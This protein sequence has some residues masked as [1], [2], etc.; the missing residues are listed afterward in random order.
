MAGVVL[1]LGATRAEDAVLW[2]QGA[3]EGTRASLGAIQALVLSGAAS[4]LAAIVGIGLPAL[5]FSVYDRSARGGLPPIP[6]VV[7]WEVPV[8]LVALPLAS[9][10]LAAAVVATRRP[11]AAGRGVGRR[12]GTSRDG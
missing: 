7:P 1:A 6:L 3:P 10:L 11:T 4:V 2:V 8:G 12:V 5:A 9:A